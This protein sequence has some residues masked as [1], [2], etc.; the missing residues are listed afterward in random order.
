M[1]RTYKVNA[2]VLARR[3]I[4]EADKLITLFTKEYGKKKVLAKGIRR[5]SSRRAP[6]LEQFS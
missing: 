3:N 5:V 1:I 6:Y 4:G 2:I